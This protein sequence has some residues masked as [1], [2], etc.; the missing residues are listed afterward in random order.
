MFS[1]EKTQETRHFTK[2]FSLKIT[3]RSIKQK[4]FYFQTID[5]VKKGFVI[6]KITR[7]D[8]QA[9]KFLNI[10]SSDYV[11]HEGQT[12]QDQVFRLQCILNIKSVTQST[13]VARMIPIKPPLYKFSCQIHHGENFFELFSTIL[14]HFLHLFQSEF[15][16]V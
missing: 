7:L 3:Q 10:L 2:I 16:T 4:D 8:F 13:Y 14:R 1:I 9:A 12:K 11:T 5:N 6:L 15:K